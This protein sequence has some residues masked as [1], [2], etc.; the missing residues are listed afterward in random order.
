MKSRSRIGDLTWEL[1]ELVLY[2]LL[3]VIAHVAPLSGPF[4]V[5]KRGS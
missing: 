1:A 2:V 5:S 3:Q 4:A